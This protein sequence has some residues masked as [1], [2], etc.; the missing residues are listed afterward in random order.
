[1]TWGDPIFTQRSALPKRCTHIVIR[2]VWICEFNTRSTEALA[3][4]S[5]LNANDTDELLLQSAVKVFGPISDH[6]FKTFMTHSLRTQLKRLQIRKKKQK[7]K[8][9]ENKKNWIFPNP[10]VNLNRTKSYNFTMNSWWI[11]PKS[12]NWIRNIWLLAAA[13]GS[14]T[15]CHRWIFKIQNKIFE[16]KQSKLSDCAVQ[17]PSFHSEWNEANKQTLLSLYAIH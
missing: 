4:A 14:Y 6:D 13:F 5:V 16:T 12:M 3:R 2:T 15:H 11:W 10:I 17:R 7:R 9:L 8:T 1:M